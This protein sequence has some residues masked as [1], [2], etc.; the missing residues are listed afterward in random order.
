[1]P[2]TT[3]A[4]F[5]V[6]ALRAFE[7]AVAET[8]LLE[9]T[10]IIG[11]RPVLLRFAGDALLSHIIPALEHLPQADSAEPELTVCLWDAVS[12]GSPLPDRPWSADYDD[13]GGMGEIRGFN[14]DRFATIEQQQRYHGVDVLHLYDSQRK[15]AMFYCPDAA[16]IPYWMDSFPLRVILH[17]WTVKQPAQLIHAGAVGLPDGGVLLAGRGGSGKSTTTV[18]C[19]NSAL[20]Y[21]GDDYVMMQLEPSPHVYS[22][23]NTAK[24]AP[25]SLERLPWLTDTSQRIEDEKALIYL[26]RHYPDKLIEGFPLK[27]ILHPRVTGDGDTRLTP[28][29]VIKVLA[30]LAPTTTFQLRSSSEIVFKK[31]SSLVRQVPLYSL[32]LGTDL[33]QIPRV[34]VELLEDHS[35]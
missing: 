3:A 14:D 35:S 15:L 20:R 28:T 24:L 11:G 25:D 1:M 26:Q 27:A 34:I 19:I 31:L 13:S 17:C 10:F 21:A 9:R 22:L 33:D 7:R 30:E 5:F 18:A 23:Y 4:V 32:E 16:R 29:T 2:D 12:T 8:Q 6:A